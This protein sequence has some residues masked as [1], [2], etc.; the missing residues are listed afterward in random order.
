MEIF[1]MPKR[2]SGKN[3]TCFYCGSNNTITYTFSNGL[4]FEIQCNTCEQNSIY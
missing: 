3:E 4:M 1:D 2:K